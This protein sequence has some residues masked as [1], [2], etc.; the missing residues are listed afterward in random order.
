MCGSQN[1]TDYYTTLLSLLCLYNQITL[2]NNIDK[3]NFVLNNINDSTKEIF[4][5]IL[6]DIKNKKLSLIMDGV[7]KKDVNDQEY[8]TLTFD[9]L[10]P[11]TSLFFT[12]NDEYKP[13]YKIHKV[14][15]SYNV[16]RDLY[17]I[18]DIDGYPGYKP[19]SLQNMIENEDITLW[20]NCLEDTPNFAKGFNDISMI[21]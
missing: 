18:K 21:C 7:F 4:I 10:M 16:K 9:Y 2:A 5:E 15:A 12:L 19:K 3:R 17:K 14:I 13:K 11:F 6:I 8:I 1:E 20:W